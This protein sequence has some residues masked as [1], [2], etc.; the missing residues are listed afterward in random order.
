MDAFSYHVMILIAIKLITY[1]LWG[2]K[3]AS[4]DWKRGSF[5]P[6]V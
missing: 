6:S 4:V 2:M 1:G 3:V 5:W